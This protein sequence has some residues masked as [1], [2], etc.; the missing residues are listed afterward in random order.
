MRDGVSGVVPDVE[1]QAVAVLQ[2]VGLRDLIGQFEHVRDRFRVHRVDAGRI[3]DVPTGN[4]KDMG[5]RDRVEVPEGDGTSGRGDLLG[6]DVSGDDPAEQTVGHTEPNLLR[7]DTAARFLSDARNSESARAR[8]REHWWRQ[9]AREAATFEGILR[10]LSERGIE[11][12]AW[13]S[14]GGRATGKVAEVSS[15]LVR[16]VAEGG[17]SVWIVRAGLAGVSAASDGVHAG[18]A[19]DDRGPASKIALAGLLAELAEERRALTARCGGAEVRGRVIG[20]GT[21]VLTL[22]L[23]GGELTY[24][25]VT[26][27]ALL[28]LA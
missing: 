11:V 9:Q 4:D 6:A 1:H 28:R 22:R 5:R 14:D 18:V 17:E 15:E 16:L 26:R 8:A 24:L 13:T 3:L 20:A 2:P 10:A 12:T 27:L 25:P 19:S 7:D 21:D 23:P